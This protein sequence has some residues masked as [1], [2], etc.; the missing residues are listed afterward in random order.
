MPIVVVASPKGGVGK[1][2]LSTQIAGYYASQ[3]HTVLLGDADPQQS[4]HLWLGL[5]PATANP[6]QAWEVDAS[7]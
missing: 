4:S 3:G 7:R 5:R 6:I 1:S 2:T